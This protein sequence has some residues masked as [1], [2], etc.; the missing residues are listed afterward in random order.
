M[1]QEKVVFVKVSLSKGV[2]PTECL[3]FLKTPQGAGFHG[4]APLHYCYTPEGKQLT[5]EIPPD[6]QVEGLVAGIIVGQ[7]GGLVR[8]YLPDSEV[9]EVS[10]DL[11]QPLEAFRS[12]PLRS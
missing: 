9:Y 4:F 3:F 5:A 2:F 11:L 8:V 7:Q 12:V 6:E 10:A 1:S